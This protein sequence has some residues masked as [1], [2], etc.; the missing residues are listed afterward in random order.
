VASDS[1]IIPVQAQYLP[2]KGMTRKMIV[3]Q[4]IREIKV[5]RGYELDIVMDMT[6]EQFFTM[7]M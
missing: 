3:C 6:Y 4:L 7:K 2:A 1:V 5:S